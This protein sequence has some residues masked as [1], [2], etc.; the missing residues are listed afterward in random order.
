MTHE[1]RDGRREHRRH[2]AVNHPHHDTRK[3]HD[4][5]HETESHDHR[6]TTRDSALQKKEERS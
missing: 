5:S 4:Q 2:A 1:V 3:N 6:S